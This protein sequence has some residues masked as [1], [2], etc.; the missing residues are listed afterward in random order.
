MKR[1]STASMTID[2]A[3]EL[4]LEHVHDDLKVEATLLALYIPEG[5]RVK[6][7]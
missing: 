7:I 6:V 3:R 5:D 4:V 2:H 1:L